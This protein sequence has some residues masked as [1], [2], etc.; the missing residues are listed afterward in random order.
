MLLLSINETDSHFIERIRGLAITSCMMRDES[1]MTFQHQTFWTMKGQPP[2]ILFRT[3]RFFTHK[4]MFE[5]SLQD[6][7]KGIRANKNNEDAYIRSCIAEIK[8]ELRS[9]DIKKKA[10]GVQKITYVCNFYCCIT[11][12]PSTNNL[13]T[14]LIIINNIQPH[15]MKP[16]VD[17]KSLNKHPNHSFTC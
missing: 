10:V 4:K 3:L 17:I 5:K 14:I 9:N 15:I 6:M 16:F 8:E 11:E 1:N 13:M 7:V 2:T 12:I